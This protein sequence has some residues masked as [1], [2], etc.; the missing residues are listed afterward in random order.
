MPSLWEV[1]PIEYSLTCKDYPQVKAGV[2]KW[3]MSTLRLACEE[4]GILVEIADKMLSL[5]REYSDPEGG[6]IISNQGKK[7]DRLFHTIP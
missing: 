3:P 6:Y 5:W 1:A 7:M 4:S 2:V